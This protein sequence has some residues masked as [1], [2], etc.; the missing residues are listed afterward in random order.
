MPDIVK[1]GTVIYLHSGGVW[2]QYDERNA[3]LGAGAMGTVYKGRECNGGMRVAIKRVVD[4]YSNVPNIRQRAKMEASL[5]FRHPNLVEMLGYC[6]LMP[7]RGPIFIISKLVQGVNIDSFVRQAMGNASSDRQKRVC[8]LFF[9]VLDALEYLHA[10]NICHLDIKPSNIMV[11]NGSNVRLMDLG[12]AQMETALDSGATMGT[13][14]Y[15]APE[16]FSDSTNG[17]RELKPYTDVYQ[18]GVTLYEL[19][20]GINPYKSQNIKECIEKHRDV[21]LPSSPNI[22]KPV[23]K[24][25]RQ[26]TSHF[27]TDRYTSAGQFKAALEEALDK[28]FFW[29]W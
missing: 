7:N 1:K 19:L 21:I 8:H 2:Y 25:L 29:P 15:A 11:E 22:T 4:K 3:P 26:A 17:S 27:F 10:S 24:V 28:K 16:Q 14:Q 13:P 20:S 9:P 18:A 12:I 23:L 5:M 6:E